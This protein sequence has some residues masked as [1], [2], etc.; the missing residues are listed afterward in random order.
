MSMGSPLFGP[1]SFVHGPQGNSPALPSIPFHSENGFLHPSSPALPSPGLRE[2]AG[3]VG[4]NH[5]DL[6]LKQLMKLRQDALG[7][8]GLSPVTAHFTSPHSPNIGAHGQLA[9]PGSSAL[10][11]AG[12]ILPSSPLAGRSANLPTMSPLTGQHDVKIGSVPDSARRKTLRSSSLGTAIVNSSPP[13]LDSPSS[14]TGGYFA[15]N[16][17]SSPFSHTSDMDNDNYYPEYVPNGENEE[18]E[19]ETD[20][21]QFD[22]TD[23]PEVPATPSRQGLAKNSTAIPVGNFLPTT[24]ETK[25]INSALRSHPISPEDLLQLGEL[26]LDSRK[27]TPV[28]AKTLSSSSIAPALLPSPP[29]SL[30]EKFAARPPASSKT[31]DEREAEREREGKDESRGVESVAYVQDDQDGRGQGKWYV[32]KRKTLPGGEVFV[33]G[34]EEVIGGRI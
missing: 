2:L 10:A 19:G 8:A 23:E 5:D 28:P 7:T 12:G 9:A 20:Y 11:N 17:P 25:G 21:D 1:S 18:D 13:R 16:S 34:R 29:Q 31:F 4:L 6:T 15:P 30:M 14:A 26:P 27:S 3:R 33:L 32:E 22:D 24:P